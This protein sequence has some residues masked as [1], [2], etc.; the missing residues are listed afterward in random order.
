MKIL[1]MSAIIFLFGCG[2]K[3]P[4]QIEQTSIAVLC[5]K[6]VEYL[7]YYSQGGITPA[8]D[9]KGNPITCEVSK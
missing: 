3:D 6:S 9:A 5:Y 7:Y 1:T 8:I 2:S 4:S